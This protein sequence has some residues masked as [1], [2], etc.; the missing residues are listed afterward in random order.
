V[1]RPC[2]QRF[3]TSDK[4]TL[5]GVTSRIPVSQLRAK[6]CGFSA[7][8]HMVVRWKARFHW[9]QVTLPKCGCTA[10]LGA[11]IFHFAGAGGVPDR[12]ARAGGCFLGRP[13]SAASDPRCWRARPWVCVR[14][15][16]PQARA[17]SQCTGGP[18]A[19]AVARRPRPGGAGQ[20][21]RGNAASAARAA[22]ST[23]GVA[24]LGARAGR[25]SRVPGSPRT[26][27]TASQ[28]ARQGVRRHAPELQD[29]HTAAGQA[30]GSRGPGHLARLPDLCRSLLITR[31]GDKRFFE[32]A[33]SSF[34]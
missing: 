34:A 27:A 25:S 9:P 13:A 1:L 19:P 23:R 4:Q 15:P 20:G 3:H 18:V 30:G 7:T 14:A 10:T 8:Q 12:A 29:R 32:A 22:L 26:R 33:A 24:D 11:A 2:L 5:S 17:L 6:T 31:F 28:R 16:V 21:G